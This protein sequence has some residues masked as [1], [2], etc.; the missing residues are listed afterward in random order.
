M[1]SNHFMLW[2]YSDYVRLKTVKMAITM[3]SITSENKTESIR[4]IRIISIFHHTNRNI[5][6]QIFCCQIPVE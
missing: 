1:S 4:K 3:N 2:M 6:E 5:Q